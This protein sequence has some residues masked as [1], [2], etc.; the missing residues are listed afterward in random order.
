MRDTAAPGRDVRISVVVPAYNEEMYL[1]DT[2]SSLLRQSFPL[3]Y[4]VIVVDNNSTDGTARLAQSFGVT[5]LKEPQPGVCAARQAGTAVARG[6]I[7]ISTDADTVHP[8]DWLSRIDAAF[9][10]SEDVILVGGPCR[11]LNPP[12]WA[13]LYPKLMFGAVGQVHLRTGRLLYITA[14]NTAFRRAAFP[15]YDPTLSQ[16]GDELDVLRRMRGRGRAVWLSHNVVSTSSRRLSRGLLYA[17]VVSLFTH[18]LLAYLLNGLT[19]Q[20][21]F[22]TA[23]AFRTQPRRRPR[24]RLRWRLLLSVAV[25][26]LAAA[27]ILHGGD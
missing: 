19:A 23:P 3:P 2:L 21:W 10:R 1:A 13:A 25:V 14:T 20:M 12:W 24:H 22:G 17:V 11:F 4:E 18:Y 7:V 6:D 5:V 15:G 9:C 27:L 8:R 26:A 16:G